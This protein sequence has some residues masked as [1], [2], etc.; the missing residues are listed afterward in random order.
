MPKFSAITFSLLKLEV[1]NYLK[2]EHNK[3]GI[4]F[5]PASPYGQILNIIENLHQLSILYL[6]NTINQFDL[7]DANSNNE[8][9]IKN[10][11]ILAGHIPFRSISATGTLRFVKKGGLKED[12]LP[13]GVIKLI[14]QST[15]KNKTNSLYYSFDLGKS[16]ENLFVLGPN[17][18]NQ[19]FIRIIQG[20]W[21]AATFTG[22]NRPLQTYSIQDSEAKDVENFNVEVLVN[23][24]Y[25]SIK[26]HIYDLLPDEQACVVRTGFNGGIDVIFGNG[27]FGAIPELTSSIR[28]R[29]LQSDGSLGNIY[30]RTVND[31]KFVTDIFDTNGQTVDMEKI[32]DIEIYNDI[33]FG[34]D[35]EDYRFTKSLL[36]IATNNFVLALPQHYV[37]E[38]KKLGIF[39]LVN[40]EEKN[41]TVYIYAVPDIRIFKRSNETYFTIPI[42]NEKVNA[43][44]YA[45]QTVYSSAFELD[46]YE[47][48]KI[49]NYLR[50]GGLT[51]LT[52][53]FVIRTPKMSF[54]TME[55]KAVRYSDSTTESVKSQIVSFMSEYFL[56][57]T[58]LTRIPKSDVIKTLLSSSDIYSIDIRFI[59]KKNEDYHKS[60]IENTVI[61]DG[62]IQYPPSY[63]PNKALGLDPILGDIIFDADELPVLRGGWYDRIGNYY[64]D[65]DPNSISN[66]PIVY[67]E[68]S[69]VKRETTVV[70]S[71]PKIKK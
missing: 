20:Q 47:R 26:K 38:L 68:I 29:Y 6:K 64:K 12:E 62:K 31:W 25:W 32:F 56:N 24:Q 34:N 17:T 52:K 7:G 27:G 66:G 45:S 1:E 10:A 30:R 21:K 53:N 51:Q 49:L 15:I 9:V 50:S 28:V 54:Y 19:F 71:V 37:Y 61:V 14:N 36:P 5:S 11:A 22:D 18:T 44:G 70:P 60:A 43:T 40:A 13:N 23:G 48:K 33:N 63:D 69:E 57:L 41:G 8:R 59:S 67:L 35:K 65:G 2:A 16:E 42:S 3:A 4:L 55:V 39:T 58:R 46:S